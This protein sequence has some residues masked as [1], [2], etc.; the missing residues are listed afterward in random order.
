MSDV[1]H[2][3]WLIPALP[4]AAAVLTAFLGPKLLRAQS[5]WPCVLASACSCVLSLFVFAAVYSGGE[6]PLQV[7]PYYTVFHVGSVDV[8][9]NLRADALTALMLVMITFIGT[10]IA[11][12]SIG[13]MHGELNGG[14]GQDDHGH[15]HDAPASRNYGY[16]RFFAEVSLFIFSMTLLVLADNLLVLYAG[17][18]GV[19]LCSYLLVG[20]WFTKPAAANAARKAFL[21]TRIGDVGLF[22][23]IMLLWLGSGY[24]LDYEGV[25]REFPQNAGEYKEYYLTLAC[26]LL[27][28]GAAGKSAQF[29]LHV[30]LPDAME[31]PTPVSALIHAA[32]MVTAGVYLIAR[33]TP[34]FVQ[35]PVAQLVVACVG[36]FTALFAALIALTQ[37]DLKRVL[38]YSTL[39]QL[40]YMFLGLGCA[41]GFGGYSPDGLPQGGVEATAAVSASMFHLFTHAF[42]KA[43]LFLAAGSVMHSM[44]NVIDMGR[45]SGLRKVLPTTHW[46]FLIGALAL[47]GLP[48][49]SGFWSKDEIVGASFDAGHHSVYGGVYFL[50]F[51]AAMVTAFLTAFY[52]FRAYFR[53]FWGEVRVPEEVGG[54]AHESPAVMTVPLIILA[55]FAAGVGAVLALPPFSLFGN[56]LLRTP[57]LVTVPEA[58]PAY[59]LM[60]VSAIVAAAGIGLAWWMYVRQPGSAA[61]V[62]Q[63]MRPAYVLSSNKFFIDELYD[64]FLIKPL[65]GF[66]QFLRV[67]D[68]YVVDGLVDI[69]GN[70]PRLL[71]ALFWPI[72]NGLVQYYAL[73]MILG[74]TVF[75]LA[76]IRYL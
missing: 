33:C 15:G 1:G 39:S 67:M 71:G 76:L 17:W 13:Y 45:F 52:T 27:L 48:P 44:G 35:A 29:P 57:G 73:L 41:V 16:P 70:I 53:T 58:A 19:G 31:G 30:W 6:H 10:L 49:F 61:Q 34:L 23:G 5:H 54:H 32:T 22:L 59:L 47:S 69:T 72:Q 50:L 18:E 46:T 40:G 75:L 66:A 38:A 65:V 36:C 9:F 43:L 8:G 74:L 14:H 12:Y 68:L 11:I 2:L 63:A 37:N 4:L 25:F 60:G 28:S 3:L 56:F 64:Y 51:I 21:V 42:F 24:H 55:V 20:F 26:L 7:V 62:A